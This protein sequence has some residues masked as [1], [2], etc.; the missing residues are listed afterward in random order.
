VGLIRQELDTAT[1]DF[2][3]EEDWQNKKVNTTDEEIDHKIEQDAIV[4]GE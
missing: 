4:K 1:E 2:Y 3:D